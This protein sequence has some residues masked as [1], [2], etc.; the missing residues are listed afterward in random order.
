MPLHWKRKVDRTENLPSTARSLCH[1]VRYNGKEARSLDAWTPISAV[2]KFSICAIDRRLEATSAELLSTLWVSWK[3]NLPQS[4]RWKIFPAM[5]FSG[6]DGLG[7]SFYSLPALSTS[8][9]TLLIKSNYPNQVVKQVP[10]LTLFQTIKLSPLTF[11]L[12]TS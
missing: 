1:S 3:C 10:C 4:Y 11:F 12:D 8:N 9:W 6:S 7:D 5:A 2:H